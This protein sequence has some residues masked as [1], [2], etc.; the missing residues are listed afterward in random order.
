MAFATD[1]MIEA[2]NPSGPIPA[3]AVEN[4]FLL[5]SSGAGVALCISNFALIE[6]NFGYRAAQDLA[7]RIDRIMAIEYD[8]QPG[9]EFRP[10]HLCYYLPK[11]TTADT[12]VSLLTREES[13]AQA[14]MAIVVAASCANQGELPI[15]VLQAAAVLPGESAPFT[16]SKE[17]LVALA[18]QKLR[19]EATL[20]IVDSIDS[21]EAIYRS[22]MRDAALY[23]SML[24]GDHGREYAASITSADGNSELY[25]S[26]VIAGVGPDNQI[27]SFDEGYRSVAHLGLARAVDQMRVGR[28]LGDLAGAPLARLGVQISIQSA[29]LDYWWRD[30]IAECEADRILAGRLYLEILPLNGASPNVGLLGLCQ[31]MRAL[32]VRIVLD[33]FGSGGSSL[34]DILALQPDYV[35]I[36][37][38]F[39]WRAHSNVDAFLTLRHLIGF[40]HSIKAP[41]IISGVDSPQLAALASDAGG[42]WHT[43]RQ[44]RF[45]K[46]SYG[47]QEMATHYY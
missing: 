26:L 23:L 35:K 22:R 16:G 44:Y 33:Q 13:I 41:T 40:A 11:I 8:C 12:S 38:S 3:G 43:G 27:A 46:A 20:K 32:G 9:D 7:K 14:V 31:K 24:L 17:G 1:S 6:K 25:R 47:M 18:R 10:G 28:A 34:R 15:P 45:N 2:V 19:S 4:S 30:I 5:Q 21:A 36:E 29:V 39:L 42:V 37:P